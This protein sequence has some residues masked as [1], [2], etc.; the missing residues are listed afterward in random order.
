MERKLPASA[1]CRGTLSCSE[2][3][4]L[5]AARLAKLSAPRTSNWLARTRLHRLLDRLS[6]HGAVWI[7]AGPGSGKSTLAA[8]WAAA[9][10]PRTL[11]YRADAGDRDPGAAFGYFT[12][13]ARGASRRAPALPAYQPQDVERLDMFARSFF[14][15]FYAVVPAAPTLVIDD[16][17]AAAGSDFDVL[18]AAAIREAPSDVSLLVLSRH[19]PTGALLDDVARGTLQR[20]EDEALAFSEDEAVELLAGRIGRAGAT[21]LHVQAA[22]WAAGML[23]LAQAPPTPGAATAIAHERLEAFFAERVLAP[24]AEGERRTLAAA[25][26]L[27]DV[28]AAGL[29]AMGLDPAAADTL[30]RLRRLHTFVTRLD[31][32]PPSWRLHDLLRDAL[33]QRFDAMADAAWRDRVRRAAAQIAAERGLAGAAVGLLLQT[34]DANGARR[35]AEPSARGLVKSMRLHELDAIAA[36]LGDAAVDGS[37]PL[38]QAL[39]ESAW[40]RNDAKA[41]VARFERAD[42]AL[43]GAAPDAR[44]LLI[45]A[46]AVGAILE[47]WQDFSGTERWMQRL[48]LHL[49]ARAQVTDADDGLRIDRACLQATNMVWGASLVDV[50]PLVSRML[51]ALRR[52][53][54]IDPNEAVAASSVLLEAAGYRQSDGL[55][56]REL[57]A[58][59]A[60]WLQQPSLAPLVKAGWLI[61]YAPLGRRWPTP[62]IALPAADPVACL[63][64]A[65]ELAREHGGR[66]VA[67]S[68]ALFL[69]HMAV[70]TND[71]AAAPGR[72]AALRELVDAGH[73]RQVI[74]VL[75]V[76]SNVLA[77]FG[78]WPAA[79]AVLRRARELAERNAWPSSQMWNMEV[80]EQRLAIAAGAHRQAREALLRQAERYP[81][82]TRRDFA[83]VLADM[84]AA[85]EAL[86]TDGRLP[87]D[88]VRAVIERARAYDWP[89]FSAH[90]AP[91]AARVCSQAIRLGIEP[92]FAARVVSDRH[93]AP[94]SPYEPHWPWPIR[95]R[96]LGGL[97]IEVDGR[98]LDFGPR[99]QRKPLDL[100]KLLIAHGPAPVDAALV[101]DALW[102]DADGAA[103]RAAFDMAVMR[104]RKLLGRSDALRL[105][106][107]HVG[108][109]AAQVWV[110]AFAFREGASDDYPGPLF[111]ADAV[112]PWWA[113][114]RERLHQRFL[115][116]AGERGR[117]LEAERAFDAA[118]AIYEAGL[119]QDPLAEE[120][121]QGAIRCHLAAGRSA[122]ALR[123]YRRCRDQLSI[124]LGVKPSAATSRLVAELI[125]V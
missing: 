125:R 77:L 96:A 74:N 112:Q 98:P 60:W 121:Y 33:A 17:H 103:A 15:T 104:L 53:R 118:L 54:T 55:L 115:R 39:G 40:Q 80:Y 52:E 109:D 71:R 14:R 87:D 62:G 32:Q 31:R 4:E 92:E 25:A 124:V 88:L 12:E 73:A 106:A 49:P 63:E 85:A 26:L 119:A 1:H 91:L 18:L 90:L 120:L 116:R 42:A 10:G 8:C 123:V 81:A 72:L 78:D 41:A 70:A 64:H 76:E 3:D 37:V 100:L 82:G 113:A 111:G 65:V 23:L 6:Q 67:F 9:R 24:L 58:A 94:P 114:A 13:L 122:D 93:L 43:G 89:G 57:V 16:A 36:A 50:A 117:A 66:S 2:E 99:A 84:A 11:W 101:L 22:G 20:V 35:M 102:P 27:P 56:F 5:A 44:G 108:F 47:G 7:A 29:A 46:S 68:G 69:A 61:T 95:V 75:E 38:L 110:D 48:A 21:R 83:L 45:A 107:S 59:S 34:G 19:E 51:D 30:E 86:Q 105:D 97:R 28:D 79:Q